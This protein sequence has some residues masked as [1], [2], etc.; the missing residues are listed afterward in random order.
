MQLIIFY[1]LIEFIARNLCVSK[2]KLL[3]H[4][5]YLNHICNILRVYRFSV[6]FKPSMFRERQLKWS[7]WT[8][9]CLLILS[10]NIVHNLQI[11][12]YISIFC[13]DT[14]MRWSIC[15]NVVYFKIYFYVIICTFI[16][17]YCLNALKY[18]SIFFILSV[19]VSR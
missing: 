6:R 18:H 19:N 8:N 11:E 4:P 17:T 14:N 3:N 12:I 5:V 2:L 16:C 13:V 10:L 9:L 1:F 15:W 7:L